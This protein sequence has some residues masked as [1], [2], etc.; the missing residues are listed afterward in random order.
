MARVCML[1]QWLSRLN[2]L[3]PLAL[4]FPFSPFL[5]SSSM[6]LAA[7]TSQLQ[8]ITLRRLLIQRKTVRTTFL[9]ANLAGVPNEGQFDTPLSQSAWIR[10]PLG[11]YAL[12]LLSSWRLALIAKRV[13]P[14]C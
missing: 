2:A 8:K 4:G 5:S 13:R 14:V 1:L 3:S 6:F 9:L 11:Q 12:Y 10:A 7:L